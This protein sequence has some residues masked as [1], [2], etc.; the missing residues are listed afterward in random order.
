MTSHSWPRSVSLACLLLLSCSKEQ[1]QKNAAQEVGVDETAQEQTHSIA[2]LLGDKLDE[3]TDLHFS[4][5][6]AVPTKDRLEAIAQFHGAS[7]RKSQK[8]RVRRLSGTCA[9][10]YPKDPVLAVCSLPESESRGIELKV[11]GAAHY[12]NP[13]TS[14]VDG[15]YA[16]QCRKL[17]GAWAK[18]P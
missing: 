14:K 9:L 1:A 2:S 17:G 15:P 4:F 6:E 18:S 13:A 12:Y 11:T 3:C 5:G 8:K 7:E 10:T 16:E